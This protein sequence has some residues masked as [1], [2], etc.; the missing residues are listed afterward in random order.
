MVGEDVDRGY[1]EV[2]FVN[3]VGTVNHELLW[4]E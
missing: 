1:R 4:G 3:A 2:R